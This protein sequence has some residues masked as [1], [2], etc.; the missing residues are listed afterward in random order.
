MHIEFR[1]S[2]NLSVKEKLLHVL[3]HYHW[4]LYWKSLPTIVIQRISR[5]VAMFAPMIRTVTILQYDTFGQCNLRPKA[6]YIIFYTV[7]I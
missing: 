5:N 6:V 3:E 1:H 4:I 7:P 2:I